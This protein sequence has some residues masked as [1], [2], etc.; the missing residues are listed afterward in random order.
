Y[1]GLNTQGYG[2]TTFLTHAA[3][4]GSMPAADFGINGGWAGLRTTK[5]LPLLFPDPQG[6]ADKRAQFWTQG[7]SLEINDVSRF[8]DGYAITKFRNVDQQ[9]NAGKSLDFSDSDMPIFRL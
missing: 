6:R 8:N 5:N 1:D 2:G 9:G 3:V 4:G 7:Q